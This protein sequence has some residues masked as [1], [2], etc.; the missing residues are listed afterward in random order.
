MPCAKLTRYFTAMRKI[1]GDG[2]VNGPQRVSTTQPKLC[3]ADLFSLLAP[4]ILLGGRER[5]TG[6]CINILNALLQQFTP[7]RSSRTRRSRCGPGHTLSRCSRRARWLGDGALSHRH[8]FLEAQPSRHLHHAVHER[9]FLMAVAARPEHHPR[10][11][12][13][14]VKGGGLECVGMG[15]HGAEGGLRGERA[16][17]LGGP[18]TAGVAVGHPAPLFTT[19]P[20]RLRRGK[21]CPR[22]GRR[23]RGGGDGSPGNWL[24]SVGGRIRPRSGRRGRRAIR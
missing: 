13:A 17:P 9:L 5:L 19:R 18:V 24:R 4:E 1:W 15:R 14:T 23:H 21:R 11:G 3:I 7:L 10:I 6:T 22:R 12:L 2:V 16:G 8:F 20:G